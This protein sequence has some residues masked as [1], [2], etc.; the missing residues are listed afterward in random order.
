LIPIAARTCKQCEK[1]ANPGRVR[2]HASR[3][4]SPEF[5]SRGQWFSILL[6]FAA[7]SR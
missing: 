2:Q 3:V 6:K 5:L 4:R 1:F 7:A